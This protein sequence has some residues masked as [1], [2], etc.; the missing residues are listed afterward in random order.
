MDNNNM[1]NDGFTSGG[2]DGGINL[3]GNFSGNSRDQDAGYENLGSGYGSQSQYQNSGYDSQPQYQNSGYDSQPQ[4]QNNGYGGSVYQ[5]LP[6]GGYEQNL[7]EPVSMG[8]WVL[9]LVLL[10]FVP[11]VNIIL[12]FV[13]GFGKKEKK[14]KSNFCKAALIMMGIMMVIYFVILIFAGVGMAALS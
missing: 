3:N 5:D 12:L 13:W 9:L 8:E 11:C 14:S 6:Q 7:E 2:T 4:Y 10:M 1:G